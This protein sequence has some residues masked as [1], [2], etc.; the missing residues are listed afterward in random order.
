MDEDDR[1]VVPAPRREQVLHEHRVQHVDGA[2]VG[3]FR[4]VTDELTTEVAQ[5]ELA[6]L[7]AGES[8][9]GKGSYGCGQTGQHIGIRR[10]HGGL[11]DSD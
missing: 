6:G 3:A 11:L 9:A 2:V 10:W 5:L 8:S 1:I 4:R 7:A